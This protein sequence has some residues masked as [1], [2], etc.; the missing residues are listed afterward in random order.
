M[1]ER[2]MAATPSEVVARRVKEIRQKRRMT[3]AQLA[4][5]LDELGMPGL[6]E[7][8]LYNLEAGR[9]DPRGRRRRAI[10]VDEMVA[11]AQAL[12]VLLLDL[13]A[14]VND[15]P[16][17]IIS[18]TG[19]MTATRVEFREWARGERPLPSQDERLAYAELPPE[20]WRQALDRRRGK[21]EET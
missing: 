20:E 18:T 10:S 13:L 2:S 11:L 7:Q 16:D 21:R 19:T 1:E 17:P 3:V 9:P 14:P 8:A 6:T 5:R 4:A 15:S 12:D